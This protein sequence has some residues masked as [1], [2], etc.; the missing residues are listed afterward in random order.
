ML[1]MLSAVPGGAEGNTDIVNSGTYTIAIMPFADYAGETA[2]EDILMPL[3]RNRVAESGYNVVDSAMLRQTLRKNRIRTF[4]AINTA[5]ASIIADE[6]DVD[7]ILLGSID[8]FL[9]NEIPEAGFS[10]R[11]LDTKSMKIFWAVSEAASGD[12]FTGLLG[13]GQ[14]RQINELAEKL[15]GGAFKNFEKSINEHIKRME[16][17]KSSPTIALVTFDNL[18]GQKFAGDVITTFMLTELID[19]GMGVIEPGTVN[20][21]FRSQNRAL[22]GEID[23]EML[24][25][26][27]SHLNVDYVITGNVN[28]F[29]A[30]MAGVEGTGPEV[31]F[32]GR[33]LD[34]ESGRIIGAY[35]YSRRGSNSTALLHSG[36]SNSLG[37]LSR[38]AVDDFVKKVEK[39]IR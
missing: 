34:S 11:L 32:D 10:A 33:C 14:I 20:E 22:R 39:D 25:Q 28:M 17:D 35:E 7:F 29:K 21:L 37:E 31:E 38:K 6:L 27:R 16:T 9:E 13:I 30:G 4:G 3:I 19:R 15:V 36:S 18:S 23:Y 1:L 26:L 12:D 5:E 8:V 24:A 2:G